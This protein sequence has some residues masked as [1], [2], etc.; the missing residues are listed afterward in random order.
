MKRFVN[1]LKKY[2]RYST[3]AAGSDLRSEV[4]NSYLNWLWWILDPL[5]FMLIYTFIM[6]VVFDNKSEPYLP[7]FVMIGI[8]I[9][10]FF[11]MMIQG[12]VT[13]VNRNRSV[14]T[15]VY[16][17]KYILTLSKSFTYLIKMFISFGL[18][19]ISMIIYRV[20]VSWNVLYFI[21]IVIVLYV[22]TF[23]MS[24]IIMHF[25]IFVEDLNNIV[26]IVLKL[27]FY[28]SGV[29]YNIEARIKP[30]YN[31]LLVKFNPVAFA[32]SSMRKA[33]LE[34]KA[35]SLKW[36]AAWFVMGLILCII[37]ISIIH[38]YENSYAKVI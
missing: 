11:S 19:V 31:H 26:K 30:P 15:K 25:G 32:M 29:F 34:Q 3:Y 5:C 16:I 12:S 38:K 27:V 18:V 37:G 33:F 13:L 1:N 21:P 36:L 17:P 14:V 28:L 9:W 23:G 6:T 22:V 10:N 20:P 2:F 35:P 8:T 7:V 24:L 4:A